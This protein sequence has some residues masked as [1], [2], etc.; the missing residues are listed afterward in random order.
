M[1][2]FI[3]DT[4]FARHQRRRAGIT[5]LA[6]HDA[7]ENGS[8]V[9]CRSGR[10]GQNCFHLDLQEH[11]GEKPR[12]FVGLDDLAV[13]DPETVLGGEVLGRLDAAH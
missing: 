4:I 11:V 8:S 5:D 6:S 3:G 12:S 2:L 7:L 9:R 10:L 1:P 13:V